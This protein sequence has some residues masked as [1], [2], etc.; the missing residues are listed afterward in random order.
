MALAMKL[1]EKGRGLT[2]PNPMVGCLIV[3]RGQ[4][5]AD[6]YHK[7]AGMDHA[8]TVALKKAGSKAQ[9]ATLYVTLEP[10]SHWGKTPPCTEAII[11]AGIT[12][13]IFGMADV[14]PK[15][16][17]LKELKGRGIKVKGGILEKEV[18]KLNEVYV[19]YITSGMPFVTLKVAMTADGNI[20]TSRGDSKYITSTEAR[21]F[22]HKLRSEVDAVL[23]G[24]NTV[25]RDNPLLNSRLVDG[26]DPLKIVVDSTL[27]IPPGSKLLREPSKLIIA[28]TKSAPRKRIENL[29]K[30]GVTLIIAKTFEGKVDLKDLMRQLGEHEIS[31]VLI[32]GGAEVNSSAFKQKVVDKILIFTAP[33]IIG[34]GHEAVGNLGITK[35]AKAIKLKD[36][37]VQKI[38]TD[39]LIEAYV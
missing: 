24:V 3:K 11:S 18:R 30:R 10:C 4:I 20:A 16:N 7:K 32:E 9:N 17:G 29:K 39:I 37:Q 28:T 21:T 38:G 15:V 31:H 33:K 26:K 6:G 13:V 34:K 23:V 19:K 36:Y 14:N 35:V 22:V 2:N 5:I 1:A 25:K 12:E 8:E 27:S